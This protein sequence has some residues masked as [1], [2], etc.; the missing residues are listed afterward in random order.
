M[1][2]KVGT[3]ALYE[4]MVLNGT[5]QQRIDDLGYLAKLY[6]AIGKPDK[7]KQCRDT[8]KTCIANV[9][10]MVAPPRAPTA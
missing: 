7:A 10:R 6:D 8:Q 9:N 4:S 1:K 3:T 5:E 2:Q